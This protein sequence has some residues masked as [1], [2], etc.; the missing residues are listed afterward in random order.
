MAK[1]ARD[2][3]NE[4]IELSNKL[5][6]SLGPETSE[7]GVR[8]GMASGPVLAGV[9]RGERARFQ[10]F[11]STVSKC[12]RLEETGQPDRIHIAKETADLIRK[13]GFGSWIRSRRGAN[14]QKADT[15]WLLPKRALRH[16]PGS[17][18]FMTDFSASATSNN[19]NSTR[20]FHVNDHSFVMDQ[21]NMD[22]TGTT[23]GRRALLR[24]PI[25]SPMVDSSSALRMS[26]NRGGGRRR[27]SARMVPEARQ[28]Q[29][30]VEKVERLVFWSAE[31][32]IQVLR[33]VA[34]RRTASKKRRLFMEEMAELE[35]KLSETKSILHELEEPVP[36]PTQNVEYGNVDGSAYEVGKDVE[37]Q[38]LD[39]IKVIATHY[40]KAN[41]F[42][43]VRSG[44]MMSR[45]GKCATLNR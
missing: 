33:H 1:F 36:I 8:F 42:S 10:V 35:A 45:S 18:H 39:Y 29:S 9:L 11:G 43:N 34:A 21:S 30:T 20:S 13:S 2:A 5:E 24:A 32:M 23:R 37:M 27:S 6:I 40:K 7:L 25:I 12:T 16:T 15:C 19:Q 22:G 41:P 4:F 38:L 44:Q 31:T 26:A 14:N 28:S 17:Q 3:L